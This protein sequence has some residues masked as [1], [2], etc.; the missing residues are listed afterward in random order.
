MGL[1]FK[2]PAFI[3]MFVGGIWAFFLSLWIV[4]DWMGVYLGFFVSFIFPPILAIAALV[5]G[6]VNG[7][8]LPVQVMY[9]S[10]FLAAFLYMFGSYLDG[11]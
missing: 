4:Q 7:E 8:W 9:G 5:E 3:I 6:F 1:L 11:D 10:T 2:L